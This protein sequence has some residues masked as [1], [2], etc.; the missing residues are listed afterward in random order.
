MKIIGLGEAKNELSSYVTQSQ[1]D[2]VLITRHGKPAA[3]MIGVEGEELE[4]LLIRANPRFWQMIEKRR[5]ESQTISAQEMR[6]RLGV[7]DIKHKP[8]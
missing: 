6:K 1:K 3:L 8:K 7:R 2:R 4:D 5:K